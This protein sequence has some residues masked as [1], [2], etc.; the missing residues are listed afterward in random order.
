MLLNRWW[1]KLFDD[2]CVVTFL[3]SWVRG[4]YACEDPKLPP[5]GFMARSLRSSSCDLGATSA[6]WH[7][8]LAHVQD[9]VG[10]R[11]TC[12]EEYRCTMFALML[13]GWNLETSVEVKYWYVIWWLLDLFNGLWILCWFIRNF[14]HGTKGIRN[15]ANHNTELACHL[16]ILC[17]M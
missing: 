1:L 10:Q 7:W 3:T 17:R 15:A 6:P 5:L 11:S 9:I 4:S 12:H 2:R 8:W 14:L 13:P 16:V